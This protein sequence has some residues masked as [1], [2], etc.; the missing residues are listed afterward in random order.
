[1]KLLLS[2]SNLRIYRKHLF[3]ILAL[4]LTSAFANAQM[5]V[6]TD[7]ICTST[8]CGSQQPCTCSAGVLISGGVPPYSILVL[9]PYGPAGTA[10][11]VSN[12]CAGT[13][14]FRVTDINGQLVQHQVII[15][16]NC[17]NLVCRDTSICYN[18]P[19]TAVHLKKPFYGQSG[20]GGTSGGADIPCSYDSIWN[21]APPV[22][23]VGIT[24]VTWWVEKNGIRDS[25]TMNVIR[26][27]PSAY[28]I[29]FTTSPAMVGGVI[30]I[31][32]GQSIT[33]NDNSTGIS[34]LLWNFGNGYY[35]SNSTHTE[36][37]SHY[38]PGTYY[39]TLTVFDACG[40]PHDTA[41]QVVVDSASGPDIYCVS[42]VCPGDTVTYHTNANC[43]TYTWS[44]TGGVF[45]PVPTSTSDSATVIWGGGPHGTITLNVSNCTPPLTC[46]FGTTK[47]IDIV[48]STMPISGDTIVCA[49]SHSCYAVEC[50][51]GNNH[52]WE[53]MPANAGTIT[54]QGTCEVCIDW[55]PGFFGPVTLTINYQNVLTGNGCNLPQVC[56]D[57]HLCGGSA[58]ITIDVRPIFGISGPQKVCPNTT[59]SPFNGMNLTNNTIAS[60]VTWKLETPIPSTL[61]FASTAL[62]NSYLWNAGAGI[63]TLHAYAPLNTYCNDSAAVQVE[64][65]NVVAPNAIVGPDTVCANSPSIYS[66]VPNM[67]GVVYTWIVSNGSIVGPSTGNSVTIQ[68]NPGGGTVSVYQTLAAA[69]GCV[70]PASPVSVVVTWPAFTLPTVT[71]SSVN[72]CMNSNVTYSFPLPLLSNATYTWSIVPAT[73]GNIITANG[74]NSITVH[75]VSAAITPIFVK[76]KITRCYSDSVMIPIN[77][78]PI[79]PVPN[80]AF[81]P[82]NPCVNDL[83]L[84]STSSA[85]PLWNWSFGDAGTSILQNPSHVYTSAGNF[86]VQLYVTN[87]N[88]CSDTSNVSI[89]VNDIPQV[90]VITGNV[91]PCVNT[92]ESYTFP[93]ILAQ[94]ASYTWSLSAPVL[95]VIQ[96]SGNNFVNVH[97]STPG[98]DTVICHLQSACLD[99]II[100]YA[101]TIHANPVPVI[102]LPSPSCVGSPLTFNGSGGVTYSWSFAS[103]SPG[104]SN[105]QNPVITY[106]SAGNYVVSLSVTDLF[107]CS[108]SINTNVTIN[109]LPLAIITGPL[110]VCSFPATV[111]MNAVNMPGYSFSWT[112]AGT[113]T[114]LTQTISV[115][116]TFSCVVTNAFGCT[117]T[118]NSIVITDGLC[119]VIPGP[120]VINDSI[121]FSWTP[122]VCL[123]TNFT[124]L[125]SGILTSWSFGD[126][127]TASPVPTVSH[128]YA[129]PGVYTAY[130]WGVAFG[131]KPNGD[132]CSKIIAGVHNVTIPFDAHFDVS[133]Q[134]NGSNQMTTVLT[135][136]S[137]YLGNPNAYTWTWTDVTT[138]TVI[139]SGPFPSP[140][141]LTPGSHVLN[142]YIYDPI[143]GAT[144]SI[145]KAV[146][147]PAPIVAA[148]TVSSPICQGA[149]NVFTD[150]SVLLA[151]ESS[152]LFNNGNGG[153]SPFNSA[154]IPYANSGSFTASINVTDIYGCASSATLPVSVIAAVPGSITVSPAACDSV[155]LTASGP[156]PFTWSV[157]NPPPVP[158][159]PAYVKTSGF[160]K[161]TGIGV[162]GCPYTAGPVSVT[163]KQSP[164]VILSG[165]VQYCQ[166]EALDLKTTTSGVAFLWQSVPGFATVGTSANLNII[167]AGSGLFTYQCT[168]TAANGCTGSAQITINVDPVPT[169]ASITASGPLTFCQGDSIKLNV[170][171]TAFAYLWSKSPAPQ[172]T[173]PT[174]SQPFIYVTQSG[175][176]SVIA[177]TPSGCA[178]P[179]IAPVTITVNPVPVLTI[180]GDTVLCEGDILNLEASQ[181]GVT[182]Y[183]WS[184][185]AG[186]SNT[187]P[188]IKSNMQVYQSGYYSVTVTNSFGC[189][190]TDSVFVLVNPAP[191]T[192]Y[193]ISNPGGPLCEGLMVTFTVT[194]PM[195]SPVYY[196]WSTGQ[197]GLSINQALQGT[198]SVVA[199]NQ[200]GCTSASNAITIHPLPD[201]SCMPSG[202]YEFCNEC[203][204]VTFPGTGGL[205]SYNW[206]TL[207]GGVWNFYS[208]SQNLT[209]YP[210]GGKFRL[211]AYNAFGCSD[212][213]DTLKI[214][215]TDCCPGPDLTTCLD[216]CI[217]FNNV[218]LNGWQPYSQAPNVNVLLSNNNSQAGPSDYFVQASDLQGPSLLAAGNGLFGKWCC[219]QFCFDYKLIND[220]VAGSPNIN[221]SFAI[222]SG[223]LG[224]KFTSTV[225]ANETNGWHQI[226]APIAECNPAP[227]S[228]AGV[229]NPVA[230]TSITDWTTVIS[231]V[232]NVLF[233]VDYTN[234]VGEV[235]AFDN[236]CIHSSVPHVDAG[237]DT[238]ICQGG[239]VTLHATGCTGTP[240]WNMIVGNNLVPIN[241]NP[242]IDVF[243]Q[244]STCYVVTC[245]GV[246][247]CCCDTDTICITVLPTPTLI[248]NTN[249]TSI[250]NN[251]SPV[252]L[253]TA[254]IFVVVNNVPVPVNAAGGS[255][256][257][258]GVGVTG[259]IFTPPGVGSWVVTYTWTGPNG[260]S[261]SVNTT[262]NVISC[263]DTTCHAFAG[264]DTTICQGEF[265]MLHASGCNGNATWYTM[266]PQGL[267]PF[268]TNP[269]IDVFPQ[270]STCYVLICC[271]P[272]STCCCDTDTICITVLPTPTLI[273][274][275]NYTSI[276][277][278]ASPVLL[279]T[280][281]IF[282]VVNNVPVPVNAAGGSG[283]FSGVGVTGN[284]FTPPGVASWVVTYTWTGPNGCSASVNTTIN[285]ISC[286]DTT[287]HAFAGND[288][289]ICQGE[290]V[291]LHASGCNGNATWYTMG[292]QGLV[293]FNTNPNIDVFP[294][295]ST[296]Y[297]LI[298]CYPNSTCCC[299]TDTICITVLPTPTLIW[300]ANYTSICNNASPVLLDTANIFVVVNNVPVP[301]NAAGGSGV[302]SGVGVSGNIF[303][304]SGV[305]SWVV[306]YTWTG[307][308]GCSASVNTTINVISC[309][310][311]TCQVSAGND[312]IICQGA[313][314]TLTA[315][316]C[317]GIPHWFALTQEGP[318]PVGD[319][320]IIDVNPLHDICYIVT[321]CFQGTACCCDTDTVCITVLPLPYLQWNN[322]TMQICDSVQ[323][324][325]LDTAN[326]QVY[327][328]NV[329]M[330]VNAAGGVGYFSGP[331]VVGNNFI[332]PGPG[333]YVITY[334]YTLPNG[335]T[336]FVTT[337]ITVITCGC[338][339]T[340][341]IDAGPDRTIC[342]GSST[343]L[344][345]TGCTGIPTWYEVGVEGL[346]QVGNGPELNITPQHNTCYVVI[347]CF[348]NSNCCCDTD[349]VCVNIQPIPVLQWQAFYDDICLN[350]DSLYLDPANIFVDINNTMMMVIYQ[351]GSGYFSGPGVIGNYFHPT[352]V[353]PHVI[354]YTWT[355]Q[356]GCTSTVTKTI[357]V[358]ICGGC[359]H[360]C[361]VDAG[362]DRTICAGSS[363]VLNVTGCTGIPTWYEVGVEGLQQVGNG[364]ELNITPQHNTC[365]VVICCFPNS[366]CCCD[367][368]TVCVNVVPAMQPQWLISWLPIC[369]YSTPF[370]LDQTNI[371]V[372]VNNVMTNVLSAGG[373]GV[374]TGTGV[375]GNYFYPTTA[376]TYT[377][378]Y[379]YTS[380]DGCV[381]TVTNTI[382]VQN[383]GCGPCY[384]SGAEMIV[385]GGFESGSAGFTTPLIPSCTC[386][387]STYCITTNAALKCSNNIS[388]NS[389]TSPTANKFMVI[390][391]SNMVPAAVWQENV[392]ISSAQNYTFTFWVAGSLDKFVSNIFR[393]NLE[394]RVGSTTV[395][396]LPGSSLTGLWR[397]F[398][399]VI[400]G[401]S[402][403]SIS[404]VQTNSSTFGLNYGLDDISLKPCVSDLIISTQVTD[405]SC[406]GGHDG[407]ISTSVSGGQLPYTYQWSSGETSDAVYQKIAG[408]YTVTVVDGTGCNHFAT[409]TIIETSS[410]T[411]NPIS[412]NFLTKCYPSISGASTYSVNS[413]PGAVYQWTIPADMQ[414]VS[415][416]GTSSIVA[417]W[418]GTTLNAIGIKGEMC[419]NAIT[420]C[421]TITSCTMIDI[422]SVAPVTPPSISGA[423]KVCPGDI[424]VYSVAPVNRAT[425]YLWTLPTGASIIG[426][427]TSN[428]ITVEYNSG[429]S[430]GVISVAASNICGSS[431]PRTR[432]VVQNILPAP[433]II[434]GPAD[435]V[436]G[437]TGVVYSVAQV[438]GA[439]S[440]D[441]TLPSGASIIGPA[442][443]SSIVVE[444][445][446]LF[447]SGN[448]AVAARNGCG[449][450]LSRSLN[451][452]AVT[453]IP[454]VISG[455]TA[456]CAGSVQNYSIATVTGASSYQWT[457]PGTSVINTGQGTKVI[458]MTYSLVP[459]ANGIVTVKAVNACGTSSVR[460][461]AVVSTN[462]SRLGDI[463]NYSMVAYPNPVS[464]ELTVEF[465]S[466]YGRNADV[467]LRDAVGQVVYSESRV[468]SQGLNST[469]INVDNLSAGI[470]LLQLYMNDRI[471]QIKVVVSK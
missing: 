397:K 116:T 288:T 307:P 234:A 466:E 67:Q 33:F 470:Y 301:V 142:L 406:A 431:S 408:N 389:T 235:S 303:T 229:W 108:S 365:Y 25:C 231:N 360:T 212:S 2:L 465:G 351:I 246:N 263:C 281:N 459:S 371:F 98:V 419:V 255:G 345:V 374:F 83:V 251:A 220:G 168:V 47:T 120:C 147:V 169:G 122:P 59:S 380:P 413:I 190:A 13:Y 243:P 49:G 429:F 74:G 428:I 94:G 420:A 11:C 256:V 319:G 225:T 175:T 131:F 211:I 88:G 215:F 437:Q 210:P 388:A 372:L 310:D 292:P 214:N 223:T 201:L 236:A 107:G 391:G 173:P 179:A 270:T 304:P 297:V 363:S 121:D 137:L 101:V 132:T 425:S 136:T 451:V 302:F 143:T 430:G 245:C 357:N 76:L 386:I 324:I 276:C 79:P 450:G 30:S 443:G 384:H 198:Y 362:P 10:Q 111:T 66:V 71:A 382:V 385:N 135:N 96:S 171:P 222:M 312:T 221:P 298:C 442:N 144:C 237:A 453:G 265:V 80:I 162:N 369:A 352:T 166:G 130:A 192:P 316:G 51:P 325:Y 78:L 455:P 295:V 341:Q 313:I 159:N 133:F 27:P 117:K 167:P 242:N 379:T 260:C 156:G 305:G 393:P 414:L 203:D 402:A 347:C 328:G 200:F 407:S 42:V 249:Y 227:I 282:V 165:N 46:P 462:C 354:T 440:Y 37:A 125:Y 127:A 329:L 123:T 45:F 150:N 454:G 1:M 95:G 126:G 373:S 367:T 284:I 326:I 105:V 84:F 350:G 219:G 118:S 160:Y 392:T 64:V 106:P 232:T 48:P 157:I 286:C 464:A 24:V 405:V 285:V 104:F 463:S 395:M 139:G 294:Q 259:N 387:P 321:C 271:Y 230:G 41:F 206:E 161:V 468:T 366:N 320:E 185:P 378:T 444:F 110:G 314:V 62:L 93:Q 293:P 97:W 331:G 268:N 456:V 248:W 355:D 336:G 204:S 467:V 146:L 244:V 433:A 415:G 278:N 154:S 92:N 158:N 349:T 194:N 209:V 398:S 69:P 257:F 129:V 89:H 174:N 279:D 289:T 299:D 186:T 339:H 416:Q 15:P 338:S 348:P 99:T 20:G 309:C 322:G 70:S 335:C 290:F 151:N 424:A 436:C 152:R 86:N 426:N 283:V 208:A 207:I 390:N 446:P 317:S 65:V 12:L 441:W 202:C 296:C 411:L 196:T 469:K 449:I 280:A 14:T 427:A 103:G 368:D 134:C 155:Q 138:A 396:T 375:S 252:L 34:G 40:V 124:K 308:N 217:N 330:S 267:V 269:N 193:I 353:G 457:V 394:V 340:C 358:V 401:M 44:V 195:P 262:I 140:A 128:T 274:Y 410:V 205:S 187:N 180:S 148:F 247:A 91:D 432:S 52:G 277:N 31:C 327:V 53:L 119:D 241:T 239:F 434:T 63:Y 254:N 21:N 275:A 356:Y 216:T 29:S 400:T 18:V 337:T 318:I 264:N 56:T 36:P 344:N 16:S 115:P 418:S 422:N 471:E 182:S 291:M 61:N 228:G 181:V 409:A 417:S 332:P 6:T 55:A 447:V 90:P 343:V 163:V 323:S 23:P 273:W 261:A 100:R 57:H 359:D 197:M 19:D 50:I 26:N 176:Y 445:S 72:V 333:S 435:G 438:L 233:T 149:S 370:Y 170:S 238:T 287:C 306:T 412:S 300:N 153:T 68:W 164:N 60:G 376:G 8:C 43:S 102:S 361:Q 39:D 272:N 112:P 383:C 377:I 58:T 28:A 213:T 218:D 177:T 38:P 5:T 81:T 346:Q 188:Y 4:M 250:C 32:N 439:N 114:S 381:S 87:A 17:C 423:A 404:I 85:G 141:L 199:T 452:K 9:G 172:L 224:F 448:I 3:V 399:V 82:P 403:S 178:Y 75:W 183:Q 226:C 461:L 109:P 35:S 189:T 22:F 240:V 258:S 334:Y 191:V 342:A 315:T 253:D 458:N 266:G 364:P 145:N 54:G 460:V 73:A 184:G 77:L 113:G 421:G 7:P 311:T